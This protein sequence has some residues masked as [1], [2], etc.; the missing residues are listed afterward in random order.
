M[1]KVVKF[2]PVFILFCNVMIF[3][4]TTAGDVILG[5]WVMKESG[6]I[7]EIYKDNEKYFARI[8]EIKS[9]NKAIKTGVIV[10]KNFSYDAKK[11]TWTGGKVF[12]PKRNREADAELFLKNNNTLEINVSAGMF[13]KTGIWT[14]EK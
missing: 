13:S 14:R 4:Q 2:L 7:A 8:V 5:R 1:K 12:A 6:N 9:E 11:K 3:S 10:L